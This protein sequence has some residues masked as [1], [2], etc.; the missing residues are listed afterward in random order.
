MGIVADI[1]GFWLRHDEEGLAS[2][3][4][5]DAEWDLVIGSVSGGDGD[6]PWPPAEADSAELLSIVT[7]GRLAACDG[8]LVREGERTDFSHFL[9]FAGT[10]KTA[11]VAAIRTYLATP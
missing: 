1:V 9:R 6:I 4:V 3:L 5:D 7:H 11:K 2:W 10:T 8:Y